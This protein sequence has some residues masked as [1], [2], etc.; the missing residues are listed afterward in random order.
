MYRWLSLTILMLT[1]LAGCEVTGKKSTT[2]STTGGSRPPAGSAVARDDSPVWKGGTASKELDG[3]MLAGRVVNSFGRPL[4][5]ASIRLVLMPADSE[6]QPVGKL[7]ELQAQP[8]RDGYFVIP[9][10]KQDRDYLYIV[11]AHD[12]DQTVAVFGNARPPQP[13]MVLTLSSEM[14]KDMPDVPTMLKLVREG[15]RKGETAEPPSATLESPQIPA[16]AP[17]PISSDRTPGWEAQIET[18]IPGKEPTGPALG[19][20]RPAGYVT[21][22]SPW[23]PP[24]RIEPPP[25]KL[26]REKPSSFTPSAIPPP[27]PSLNQSMKYPYCD[28]QSGQL[29]AFALRDMSGQLY[30]FRREQHAKLVLLHFWHTT[31]PPCLKSIPQVKNWQSGYGSHGLEVIGICYEDTSFA[32][33]VKRVE[34]VSSYSTILGFNYSMLLGGDSSTCPMHKKLQVKVHPTF[35][36]LD[37]AG[38]IVYHSEEQG[39]DPA[40]LDRIIRERLNIR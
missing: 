23:P 33:Q 16:K 38:H 26:E 8:D 2:S 4:P 6:A 15:H 19:T 9:N 36:L 3:T 30:E 7:V 31:C 12:G 10:L 14:A 18:P 28:L 35:V 21:T 5:D 1:A 37:Q 40:G 25:T 34:A 32:E 13:R 11:S 24:A 20:P 39:F 17:A 22:P 27:L 29:K